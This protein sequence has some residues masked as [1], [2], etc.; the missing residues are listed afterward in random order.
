MLK[1]LGNGSCF[2]TKCG[3]TSAYYIEEAKFKEG[4]VR[5]LTL[6][7]CGESVFEKIIEKNI[8]ENI[9]FVRIFITHTHT[10]HIGSLSSLIF[11]LNF[12]MKIKPTILFPNNDVKK[13]LEITGVSENLYDYVIL[14]INGQ[15]VKDYEN[16]EKKYMVKLEGKKNTVEY[17]YDNDTNV[18]IPNS[19]DYL[20]YIPRVSFNVYSFENLHAENIR[21][22]GYVLNVDG[23]WIYYGSDASSVNPYIFEHIKKGSSS[24]IND[25]KISEFYIECTCY[26]NNVHLNMSDFSSLLTPEEKKKITLMHF[27]N[28]D[29]IKDALNMGFNV[30]TVK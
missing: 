9:D 3:N 13:F 14:N 11:Y 25:P 10:D 4:K 16:G 2:N 20:S 18:Y 24:L 7:D 26:K 12:V 23:K 30:A 21:S 6:F 29:C 27:D 15:Y 1:F 17:I 22:F 28:E 8:I 5:T 19:L